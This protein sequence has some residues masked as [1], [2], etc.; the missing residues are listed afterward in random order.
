MDWIVVGW[1]GFVAT[2]FQLAYFGLMHSLRLSRFSPTVQVGCLFLRNPRSPSTDTLGYLLLLVLG[3]TVVPYAYSMILPALG[4]ASWRTGA[5][6]GA[7]HGLAAAAALP[8]LGM[9]SACIRAGAFPEP[10]PFGIGWG[11]FTPASV[12]LGHLLYGAVAGAILAGF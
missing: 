11:R 8:A 3:S 7:G 4:G 6:L 9:I 10:G 5:L 2:L 1:A 12:V